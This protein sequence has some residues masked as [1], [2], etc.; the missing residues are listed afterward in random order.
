MVNNHPERHDPNHTVTRRIETDIDHFCKE[1][2]QIIQPRADENRLKLLQ[3]ESD[4]AGKAIDQFL[5]EQDGLNEPIIARLI[6]QNIPAGSGLFLAGSLPIREMDMFADTSGQA[7][8][9]AANR[10]VSGIDGT[11][12]SAAGYAA[13]SGKP[14]TLL[15]GDLAFLHDLN[16]LQQ[17]NKIVQP[18]TIVLI[19]NRGGG[20]FSFL[21]I[22]NFKEVFESY[23]GTPHDLSFRSAAELFDLD[24][25]LPAVATEF[26]ESYRKALKSKKSSIIEVRTNRD[27]N[28]LLQKRLQENILQILE[29]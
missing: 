24:Y 4:S 21:P 17:L 20:I 16:S 29:K 13:G 7:V 3:R 12:A 23:F 26:T 14:V 11:I 25:Y 27:E 2:M 8:G 19:N 28:F 9:V 18:L 6:S 5:K 1:L 10:G 15:V 22:V